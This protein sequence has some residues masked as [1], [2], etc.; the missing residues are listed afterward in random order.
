MRTTV[1]IDDALLREVKVLAA[2]EERT[3]SSVLEEALRELF[4][5][6]RDDR[7]RRRSTFDLPVLAGGFDVDPNDNRAV[8]D[9]VEQDG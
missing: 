3:V 2:R 7:A 8:R 5:R 4:E 9:A 1:T 6:S